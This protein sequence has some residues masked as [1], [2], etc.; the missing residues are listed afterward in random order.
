MRIATKVVFD[1]D[2]FKAIPVEWYEYEG[3]VDWMRGAASA[4]KNQLGITNAIGKQ[5]QTKADTLEGQ[6]IPGYTSLMSTGY[7][8]PEEAAAATTSEM[9]AATAP[10]E[11]AGFEAKNRAAATRNASDLTA[12]QD[13]LALEEGRTAGDAAARLQEEKMQNQLSGMYGLGQEQQTNVGEAESMYG[14]APS[15]IN[16]WSNAQNNN[17]LLNFASKVIGAAGTAYAG[18]GK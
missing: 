16:A 1:P 8:N 6:L 10:F 9:G 12:Q 18:A 5:E 3:P 7:L 11:T 2:T 17:P 14:L 15:T 4:A 13:Q